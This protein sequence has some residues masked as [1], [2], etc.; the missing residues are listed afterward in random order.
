MRLSPSFSP[1]AGYLLNKGKYEELPAS[2]YRPYSGE[3][4]RKLSFVLS[5]RARRA[6]HFAF[7]HGAVQR[8]PASVTAWR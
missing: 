7:R 4:A 6:Q 1:C 2:N 3:D 8:S 5:H